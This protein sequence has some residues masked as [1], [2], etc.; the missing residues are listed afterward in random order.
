[1]FYCDGGGSKNVMKALL[2]TILPLRSIHIS[3]SF[4]ESIDLTS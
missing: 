4:E 3:V 1:M 2:E